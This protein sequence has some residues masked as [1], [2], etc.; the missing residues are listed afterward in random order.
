MD[1]KIDKIVEEVKK[2]SNRAFCDLINY[3]IV[4]HLREKSKFLIPKDKKEIDTRKVKSS[5]KLFIDTGKE[6][7]YVPLSKIEELREKV[8]KGEVALND[9]A[10]QVFTGEELED[11]RKNSPDLL[12]KISLQLF[13]AIG[14]SKYEMAEL[15]SRDCNESI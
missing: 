11:I 2:G 6:I 12:P 10:S 13:R 14:Y 9:I 1:K 3:C 8:K 4:K 15:G 7:R 5:M